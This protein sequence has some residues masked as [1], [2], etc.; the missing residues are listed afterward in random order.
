MP[1]SD[2]REFLERSFGERVVK[3]TDKPRSDLP[4][5]VEG[6]L[7]ETTDVITDDLVQIMLQRY[8]L[9]A[10]INVKA[11]GLHWVMRPDKVTLLLSITNYSEVGGATFFGGDSKYGGIGIVITKHSEM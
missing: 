11:G 2:L 5:F 9:G 3:I 8:Y 7:I 1:A 4:N 6:F 10:N